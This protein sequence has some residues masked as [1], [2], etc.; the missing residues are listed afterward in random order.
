MKG[1]TA[2]EFV[3]VL[4]SIIAVSL[5]VSASV[6][7]SFYGVFADSI[8]KQSADNQVEELNKQVVSDYF[9]CSIYLQE[10]GKKL[11]YRVGVCP[12][13]AQSRA[14]IS[15]LDSNEIEADIEQLTRYDDVDVRFVTDPSD[16]E[17]NEKYCTRGKLPGSTESGYVCVACDIRPDGNFVDSNNASV[18]CHPGII[19]G[20]V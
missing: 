3:L 18:F 8:L 4:G 14:F 12:N 15:L 19:T 13:D 5:M 17:F 2:L 11:T 1:Q 9:T 6:V 20:D 16:P 10:Q 7:N